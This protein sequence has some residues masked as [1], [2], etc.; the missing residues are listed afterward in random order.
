MDTSIPV[1]FASAR[2]RVRKE[3]ID[4]NGHMNVGYYHVAFDNAAEPF[5]DFLGLTPEFRS[6]HGSSTFALETHLNFLREVR[7]GD[8]LRFEARLIDFD[9]KRI[10]FFQEMFHEGDGYVAASY[11]SVSAH[12]SMAT[13]RTAPMPQGLASRLAAVKAAHAVLPRPW[14]LGHAISA[15]PVSN[16]E[17]RFPPAGGILGSAHPERIGH[18]PKH[19]INSP[20]VAEPPPERWSNAI[21]A[22]EFLFVSGMVSRSNEGVIEGKGEYEQTKLI[23]TK[24]RHMVE[25]AGGSMADVVKMTIFVVNIKQNT[26]VWRARRE[27]FS[28]DFPASTLVEVRALATPDILVEIEVVAHIGGAK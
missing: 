4:Y 7:A 20:Q 14:Q 5:F 6:R 11:E 12:V 25:A 15:R 8:V 23:F 22:G 1:P 27:F 10:H 16:P 28:G 13:R 26:E 2:E 9:A 18:M 3:W 19:R 24:I 21:R 17:A